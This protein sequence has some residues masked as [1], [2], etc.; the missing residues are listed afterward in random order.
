MPDWIRDFRI[1][2]D[3]RGLIVLSIQNEF[4]NWSD[5]ITLRSDTAAKMG[6]LLLRESR[7][8]APCTDGEGNVSHDFLGGKCMRCK[9]VIDQ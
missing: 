4:G 2:R 3:L 8:T 9:L 7:I 5:R 6:H 1:N